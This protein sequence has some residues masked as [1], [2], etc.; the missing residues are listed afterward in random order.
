MLYFCL[1]AGLI[2][3]ISIFVPMV[4]EYPTD[5]KP[6]Q[7]FQCIFNGISIISGAVVLV[8]SFWLL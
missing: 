8:T 4:V 1:I 3:G 6:G 7:M 5:Y 2:F